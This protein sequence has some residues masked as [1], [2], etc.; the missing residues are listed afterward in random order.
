MKKENM[1]EKNSRSLTHRGELGSCEAQT[2]VEGCEKSIELCFVAVVKDFSQ[3]RSWKHAQ[4]Q[5]MAASDEWGGG[6][7]FNFQSARLLQ[8]PGACRKSVKGF[9]RAAC[10]IGPRDPHQPVDSFD[11]FSQPSNRAV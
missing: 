7:V 3:A 6:F 8:Q 9:W 4:F 5:Q 11:L 2:L 1:R 10:V